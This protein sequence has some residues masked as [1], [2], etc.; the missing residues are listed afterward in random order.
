MHSKP[1]DSSHS[2]KTSD[3]QKVLVLG[4][5][6]NAQLIAEQLQFEGFETV[7]PHSFSQRRL[8]RW[9]DQ[10]SL[11]TIRDILTGFAALSQNRGLIH[12]GSTIWAERPE[13]PSIA[14]Q[15][16]LTVIS[17]PA[18]ILS[19]FSNKLNLLLAAGELGISNLLQ[20]GDLMHS[21]REIEDFI[22]KSNQPFP[23]ILRSAKGGG[24]FG[25]FLVQNMSSLGS[26]LYLWCDQLRK[27]QGEVILFAERYAE[28]ARRVSVPFARF[29][30]GRVQIF[31]II[32]SSLQ[33]LQRK[34]IEFC[35]AT[36]ITLGMRKQLAEW[37][38]KLA[39]QV[40][41][42]GVGVLEFLV[43][44]SRAFLLDG[45][46]RLNSGFYLWNRVA[47]TRAISWQIA[48]LQGVSGKFCP[49][50]KPEKHWIRGLS[51][52][53][54]AEDS[55]FH[56][57]QAGVVHELSQERAWYG[58]G[59]MEAEISLNYEKGDQIAV[60]DSGLFAIFYVAAQSRKELMEMA[61][62]TLR[63]FW[64]AGSFQ[65][66]ER[67]LLELMDHPWLREGIFHSSFVDEEFIP[68]MRPPVEY[69]R[70][71]AKIGQLISGIDPVEGKEV[72][73]AIGDQWIKKE[74]VENYSLKWRV[75]PLRWESAERRGISGELELSENR[76]V[77]VCAYPLSSNR[78]AIRMGVWFL[79]ARFV[80]PNK[81]QETKSK[82]RLSALVSGRVHALF[83]RAG[84]TVTPHDPLVI[85][86]S[87]GV[88]V[89]HALP[90]RAKIIRWLV[91]AEE[92]VE[93]GQT[94]AEMS[95]DSFT[96]N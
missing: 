17:P 47:G 66:N 56:L 81:D 50:I 29:Q 26:A 79:S 45:V 72:R 28:G 8:P 5:K 22:E 71:C 19:F 39:D 90:T 60:E 65:T 58:S 62:S 59:T 14:Q 91:N 86:E 54:Y 15:L 21:V 93:V 64:A 57:P 96:S 9:G 82:P 32:D 52:R 10:N 37:T 88:F 40:G 25:Q 41:Y 38:F 70:S 33:C 13:L 2:W 76:S 67:F 73:W 92:I 34:V 69:L 6:G 16:G 11:E 23:F 84:S 12:P 61:Q 46:P 35:P 30:D 31:P 43:D 89:P 24:R 75:E 63:K 18:G 85:I 51:F 42:V 1:S 94:L 87:M 49:V 27:A 48:T 68:V 77:R 53:V 95:I 20:G 80:V 74:D 4:E 3:R 44:S 78:W 83:F 36:R 7:F 55:L